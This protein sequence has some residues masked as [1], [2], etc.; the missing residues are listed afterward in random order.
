MKSTNNTQQ[1][2]YVVKYEGQELTY[3]LSFEEAISLAISENGEA[4]THDAYPLAEVTL[5][6]DL[7]RPYTSCP[8]IP[9][10]DIPFL[11]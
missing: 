6:R 10:T 4:G 5:S 8:L 7:P 2:S 9:G 1:S 11:S 3:A